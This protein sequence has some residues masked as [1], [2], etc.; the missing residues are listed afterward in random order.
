ML[1]Y[2]MSIW[3]ILQPFGVFYGH[4]LYFMA[5]G[6]ICI[7]AIGYILWLLGIFYGHWVHIMAIGYILWPLGI[8]YGYLVHF[9]PFR[10]SKKNL[11]TLVV[12]M[13]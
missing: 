9:F 3:F 8:F 12:L 5:I 2:F 13:E 1:A 6:Y 7:M 11:A 10:C 4:W